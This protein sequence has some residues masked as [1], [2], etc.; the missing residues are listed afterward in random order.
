MRKVYFTGLLFFFAANVTLAQSG[1][2]T[3]KVIDAGSGQVL[4]GATII[5]FEKSN[6]FVLSEIKCN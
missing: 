1:K 2:I 5:L 3:G 6:I 4:A